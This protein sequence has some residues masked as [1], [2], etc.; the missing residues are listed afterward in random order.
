M[1]ES[2]LETPTALNIYTGGR[3]ICV[4]LRK[5]KAYEGEGRRNIS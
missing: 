5:L 4:T 1:R 2:E 3:E